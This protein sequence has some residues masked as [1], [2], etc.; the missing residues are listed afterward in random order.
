MTGCIRDRFEI[1]PC[2]GGARLLLETFSEKKFDLPYA[3]QW[4]LQYYEEQNKLMSAPSKHLVGLISSLWPLYTKA[5]DKEFAKKDAKALQ[6]LLFRAITSFKRLDKTAWDSAWDSAVGKR[7]KITYFDYAQIVLVD[8][9]MVCGPGGWDRVDEEADRPKHAYA[10]LTLKEVS[11]QL[12][13]EMK[14]NWAM[15]HGYGGIDRV[16]GLCEET[17]A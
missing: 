2:C 12:G 5:L 3:D 7:I 13:V 15:N 11:V 1:V 6:E 10:Y 16:R 4:T 17:V 8:Q 9:N 14:A